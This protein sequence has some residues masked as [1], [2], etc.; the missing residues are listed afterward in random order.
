MSKVLQADTRDITTSFFTAPVSWN[1]FECII[2]VFTKNTADLNR[3]AFNNQAQE[4]LYN[5]I[6]M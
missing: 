1:R 5:Q 3:H 2:K 6:I 4:P